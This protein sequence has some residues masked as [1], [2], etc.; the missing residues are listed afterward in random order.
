[1]PGASRYVA[2]R[3]ARAAL[4][5]FGVVTLVFLLVRLVPGDPIDAI[6]GDQAS[7]EDRAELRRALH[8]DRSFGEQYVAFVGD[9]ANGS[10]G[11]S[12]RRRDTTV[13]TLISEVLPDTVVLALAA[14]LVA[15]LLAVPLGS[16]AAAR[17]GSAW[18]KSA[19]TF[20]MLGI[21][22][23]NIWLGPLLILFFGVQL[24]WLP[25]PGDDEAGAV[26]LILPAITIGTALA[27]VLTRQTRGSMV[28]VLSEQYILAARARGLS[29]W[30]VILKHGLRNALLPVMTVGAAQ[31]GALLSGTVIAE[32]IF[33]RRG[34][35][36]LFLEGFFDRDIPV[37]Q[38]C[39][40]VIAVIYV[41]VN[42]LVD[43]LY[44]VVDPRV[45]L[46]S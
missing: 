25:L 1:M 20:A 11:T 26:A 14:L 31:L 16:I 43:L 28:E 39:V 22:I 35:G 13:T 46:S 32:K 33:E 37:V 45:R 2:E 9:V 12:F 8:L 19:T 34:L 24:R 23:P 30:V 6:L 42:L 41:S 4:T 15:W 21:A 40:L 5:V 36:T 27:A 18:D 38:G 29:S 3:I 17:K 44:V 10:L 7:P